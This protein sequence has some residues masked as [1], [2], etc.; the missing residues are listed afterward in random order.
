[1]IKF[2]T[3]LTRGN[4]SNIIIGRGPP[5]EAIFG[6]NLPRLQELKTKYDPHNTFRQWHNIIASIDAPG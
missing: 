3:D 4:T 5:I 6:K 1:L 2:E